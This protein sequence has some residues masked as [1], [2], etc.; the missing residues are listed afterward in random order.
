MTFIQQNLLQSVD[1]IGNNWNQKIILLIPN[2]GVSRTN[3]KEK[4][5]FSAHSTLRIFPQGFVF[6]LR[7]LDRVI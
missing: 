5:T 2:F 6:S 4:R 3:E 7:K 1:S